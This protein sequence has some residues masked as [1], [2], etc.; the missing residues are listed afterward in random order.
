MRLISKNIGKISCGLLLFCALLSGLFWKRSAPISEVSR[1]RAPE[2]PP[3][4]ETTWLTSPPSED[5]TAAPIENSWAKELREL[6][7]LAATEPDVALAR[8]ARM[9]EKHERKIAAGT[10]CLVIAAKDPGKAMAAAWNL[11]LG[12]FAH[13]SSENEALENLAKQW[14]AADLGQAFLWASAL[15]ADDESRRD[16]VV[17]GIALA[18]AQIAPAEAARMVTERM[19]PDSNVRAEAT[20]EV[21]RQWAAQE[22]A[23]A[24]AWASLFPEGALRQRGIETLANS[25]PSPQPAS[26]PSN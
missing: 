11:E 18:L 20:I 10:V 13:E 6:K 12:K 16:H 17:K 1:Q 25:D 15:P 4:P 22:Y 7:T 3:V 5:L 24:L 19:D 21:L 14:A 9:P 2:S 8:V 26:T 23:G